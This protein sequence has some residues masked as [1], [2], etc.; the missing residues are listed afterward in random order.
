MRQEC[1]VFFLVRKCSSRLGNFPH[2]FCHQPLLQVW[3]QVWCKEWFPLHHPLIP[4]LPRPLHHPLQCLDSGSEELI[5]G[6]LLKRTIISVALES[7]PRLHAPCERWKSSKHDV[8]NIID[9]S[10]SVNRKRCNQQWAIPKNLERNVWIR[11]I[12]KDK[13]LNHPGSAVSKT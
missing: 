4:N 3:C 6:S 1:L 12:L 5:A 2:H 11:I 8:E 10:S 13:I 7:V 9:S